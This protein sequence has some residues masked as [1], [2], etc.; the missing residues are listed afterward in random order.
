MLNMIINYLLLIL[1]ITSFLFIPYNLLYKKEALQ[2]KGDLGISLPKPLR[3]ILD[4]NIIA[5]IFVSLAIFLILFV[6]RG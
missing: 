6:F 1:F 4:I 2:I 3:L 5:S